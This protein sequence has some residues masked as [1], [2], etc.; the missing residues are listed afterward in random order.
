MGKQKRPTNYLNRIK[1]LR[2]IDD[3]FFN[4]FMEGN[5]EDM[6][7]FLRIILENSSLKVDAIQTQRE[8]SNIYGRSVRFDV[9][10]RNADGT[11]CNTEIQRTDIAAT[12]ERARFNASMMDTLTVKSG[13]EWGK[14]HLPPTN[15]IFITENDPLGGGL[16]IYHIPRVIL[17]MNCKR[18][19]DKAGIIYVNASYQDTATELGRLMHDMFCTRAE[20]MYYQQLSNR[21][22]YLKADEHGVMKMCKIMDE[23]HEDGREEGRTEAKQDII[24]QLVKKGLGVPFIADV[25]GWTIEQVTNF[26]HSKNLQPAQ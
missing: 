25:T 10:T 5:A 6:E 15:V 20:D 26:L 1:R 18:F 13:F 21:M 22:N 4:T 7:L 14:N 17:E 23:I 8:V 19:E 9:F 24:L 2:L 3:T 16:P 12:P 11:I